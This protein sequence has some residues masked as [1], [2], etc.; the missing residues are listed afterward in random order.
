MARPVGSLAGLIKQFLPSAPTLADPAVAAEAEAER[1][2]QRMARGR[3]STIMT[4]GAG[5][6]SSPNLA[7]LFLLGG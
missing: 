1:K 2:R 3:A 5:D 7:Q 6:T 4:G